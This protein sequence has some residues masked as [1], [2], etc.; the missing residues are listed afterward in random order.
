MRMVR[1]ALTAVVILVVSLAGCGGGGGGG[2][3]TTV[4]ESVQLNNQIIERV[5]HGPGF[6]HFCGLIRKRGG[7]KAAKQLAN[8]RNPLSELITR[9]GGDPFV[10]IVALARRCP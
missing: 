7:M 2:D 1:L 5:A 6:A 8:T 9:A 4:Y 10:V 3:T